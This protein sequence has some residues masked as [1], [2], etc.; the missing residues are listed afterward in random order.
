[1]AKVTV[2]KVETAVV[3]KRVTLVLNIEEA[4]L[5]ASMLGSLKG[6]YVDGLSCM[7]SSIYNTMAGAGLGYPYKY[8]RS[9]TVTGE[10]QWRD[11]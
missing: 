5:I 11:R 8:A 9:A 7:A 6:P 10:L 1:M 3:I 4:T 2:D